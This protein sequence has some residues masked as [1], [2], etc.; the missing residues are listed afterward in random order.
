MNPTP[1]ARALSLMHALAA[2]LRLLQIGRPSRADLGSDLKAG[3][4]LGVESVPDG[5]ATGL[6]AGVN[7]AYG[8][9]AYM[10]GTVAGALT[11]SSVFMT[12][13]GTGAMA[14]LVADTD[15]VH[16][17]G[18]PAKALFTLSIL[19]GLVMFTLGLLNLGSLV[20]FVPNTVVVGFINAVAINII[21]GQF[22]NLTAYQSNAAGRLGRALDTVVHPLELSWQSIVVGA[23]TVLLI[24]LLERTRMGALGLVVAVIAT[25]AATA[26][27]PFLDSVATL[28]D[29][30]KV[31][32]SLP[33]PVLPDFGL[34]PGLLL[35]AA[36]LA[37]IGL[38]QGAGISGSIP[39]PDGRYP[40]PSGDF[41]GQGAANVASG[42]LQG[43]PVGGSL[44]ATMV[45]RTAGARS[46]WASVFAGVVMAV[47]VLL[48]GNT[49]GS[50]A[51]P[52]LAGLLMLVGWRTLKVPEVVM[53][54]RTGPTQAAVMVVTFGLTLAIPLQYAVLVGV[55]LSVILHV[56]RQSNKITVVRWTLADDGSVAEG[57]VPA[58]L[59]AGEVVV[60]QP[61]GSLFFA[62]AAAFEAQLPE[63]A[64]DSRGSVVVLRL[65]GKEQLGS[66]F[67]TVVR[68]YARALVA[69]DSRLML[70]GVSATV[71]EQLRATGVDD[72]LGRDA[73]LTATPQLLDSLRSAL[74]AAEAWQQSHG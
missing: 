17:G 4:T 51:M 69:V 65:R 39:N 12:V 36:S 45:A 22:S 24:L 61:Y 21:L 15:Q 68:R 62:A 73:V 56:A 52:A 7:P 63:V 74:S 50:I 38:V 2:R 57:V 9:Y 13:Q 42:L 37:L 60:L 8:L 55:G 31:P 27:L 23:I 5:L 34:V 35:P 6:L 72:V 32:D 46:R 59:P 40:D 43:M 10:V 48:L 47:A 29:L 66:T 58:V 64:D 18:A 14:V 28:D 1:A 54:W 26:L 41:R 20:R 71:A 49:L 25:S 3:V 44:S 16:G 67:I 33:R 70:A 30:T 53:V 11:T 19:T